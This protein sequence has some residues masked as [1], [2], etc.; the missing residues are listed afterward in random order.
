LRKALAEHNPIERLEPLAKAKIP[1]LHLHGNADTL[2][3][4]E[5]NSAELARRYRRLGG[6]MELVVIEGKGHQ[7]CPEFF[8]SKRLL[9]FFLTRGILVTR[10]GADVSK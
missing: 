9:E 7:V 10:P 1:I 6:E 5:R 3:P 2:V 4:L 8:E